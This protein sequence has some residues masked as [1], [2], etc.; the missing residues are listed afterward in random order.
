MKF[1]LLSILAIALLIVFAPAYAGK[2]GPIAEG[3]W[4]GAGHAVYPDGTI[5]EITRVEALLS[6]DGNFIYGYA[7]FDVTIDGYQMDT[8]VGQM[9]GHLMGNKIT[10]VLGGCEEPAPACGGAGTFD[11]KLS[12]NRMTG[13]MLDLSDGSTSYI[14]LRRAPN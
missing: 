13:T 8:Q 2:G 11:G 1:K 14:V 10:G 12:G 3:L 7:E 9:S 4:L 6:Q 5:A